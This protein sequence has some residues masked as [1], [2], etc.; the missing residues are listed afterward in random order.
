[1]SF[2][3]D[4]WLR[5]QLK[6]STNIHRWTTTPG[7]FVVVVRWERASWTDHKSIDEFIVRNIVVL[8]VYKF[9]SLLQLGFLLRYPRKLSIINAKARYTSSQTIQDMKCWNYQCCFQ[10]PCNCL[11]NCLTF[12]CLWCPVAHPTYLST[13]STWTCLTTCWPTW[14]WKRHCVMETAL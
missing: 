14:L 1:M 13:C 10:Q 3:P 12:R 6:Y 9:V 5:P 7:W 4:V 8:D 11:N 2:G